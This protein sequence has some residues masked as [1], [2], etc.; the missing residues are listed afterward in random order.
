ME[1][2]SAGAIAFCFVE[3][4]WGLSMCSQGTQKGTCMSLGGGLGEMSFR[5]P[6][7]YAGVCIELVFTVVGDLEPTDT[8]ERA[9]DTNHMMATGGGR[10]HD[11]SGSSLKLPVSSPHRAGPAPRVL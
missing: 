11:S 1:W 9:K 10:P 4:M 7:L 5:L 2:S 3:A 6:L 8:V